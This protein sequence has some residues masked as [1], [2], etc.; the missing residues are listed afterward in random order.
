MG[1][2]KNLPESSIHETSLWDKNF[3]RSLINLVSEEF[4]KRLELAHA[5]RPELFMMG[6]PELLHALKSENCQPN[7]TEN[8][9][10]LKFW[11]EYDFCQAQHQQAIRIARVVAGVVTMPVF[12][13]MLKH[14]EKVAWLLCIPSAYDTHLQE[15]MN[16]GARRMREIMELPLE[17]VDP[18]GRKR[19]NVKLAELQAKIYFAAEVR[20]YGAITQ[21]IEQKTLQL[22][23]DGGQSHGL[24]E[25][26]VTAL[27]DADLERRMKI[28]L[29]RERR[30]QHIIENK[31]PPSSHGEIEAT[32]EPEKKDEY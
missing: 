3:P 16:F 15:L 12:F 10:R 19:I 18:K 14:P 1:S 20:K 31:K 17:I 2:E 4:G 21:K 29:D 6:E 30:A 5:A 28:L 8:K 11:E 9:I 26:Q 32:L 25:K 13:N 27:N 24:I 22:N 23:V 7:L